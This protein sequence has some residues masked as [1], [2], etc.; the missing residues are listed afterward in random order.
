MKAGVT[1]NQTV[2]VAGSKIMQRV[3]SVLVGRARRMRN[4]VIQEPS[5]RQLVVVGNGWCGAVR[6]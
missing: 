1:S 4:V 6:L 2:P 5:P 3:S